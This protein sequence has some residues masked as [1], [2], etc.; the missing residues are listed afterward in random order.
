MKRRGYRISESKKREKISIKHKKINLDDRERKRA[1]IGDASG[2]HYGNWCGPGWSAGQKKDA[3][4]LTKADYKVPAVNTQDAICKEHDI[5]IA[6]AETVDDIKRAD[7]TFVQKSKQNGVTGY[8][9]AQLVDH[10][11]PSATNYLPNKRKRDDV[12]PVEKKPSRRQLTPTIRR[13]LDWKDVVQDINTLET[14]PAGRV[15]LPNSQSTSKALVVAATQA[16]MMDTNMN[17]DGSSGPGVLKETPVDNPYVIYRGPPDYTFASLPYYRENY[18][19]EV[20]TYA[21]DFVYRMTSVYDAIRN[22][23]SSD[24]NAGAGT[25]SV[26]IFQTTTDADLS[27]PRWFTYYSSLYSYYKVIS[28]QYNVYIEN[29]DGRPIWAYV[30]FSNETQ[31][32]TGASNDDIQLWKGVKYHYIPPCYYSIVTAGQRETT[33]VPGGANNE[34]GNANAGGL[35]FELNDNISSG[36]TNIATFT[37]EYKPGDFTREIRLDSQVENWT[38]VNAN[39]SLE[40]NMIIRLKPVNNALNLNNGTNFGGPLKCTVRVKMNYL[41]EFK[42]LKD[43]LRWPVARQPIT[44]VTIDNSP[45]T[46]GEA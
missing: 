15:S 26:Q 2:L 39:P 37:G 6:E 13:A 30:M 9:M 20:N 16:N 18:I 10:F 28:C 5:N 12:S 17:G 33:E 31:P 29:Y 40:E 46:S 1:R 34:A 45:T 3:V 19:Q 14:D 38:A 32:P 21:Y 8:V 4:E 35:N 44:A 36:R 7:E 43:G 27:P 22:T 23:S 25:A 11:G 24:L 42:E 41:V